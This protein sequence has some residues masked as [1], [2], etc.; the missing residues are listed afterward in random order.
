VCVSGEV[1]G[2]KLNSSPDIPVPKR[3]GS[4]SDA[5]KFYLTKII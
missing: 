3:N 1:S 4:Q 2:D 5:G